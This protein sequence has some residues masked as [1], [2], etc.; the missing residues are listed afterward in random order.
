[1]LEGTLEEIARTEKLDY[2]LVKGLNGKLTYQLTQLDGTPL[3]KAQQEKLST[4]MPKI[5]NG[6]S[7]KLTRDLGSNIHLVMITGQAPQA[8]QQHVHVPSPLSTTPTP[9][10]SPSTDKRKEE[11]EK[12]RAAASSTTSFALQYQGA[13]RKRITPKSPFEG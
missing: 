11:E 7:E 9:G 4:E 12:N 5:F 10:Q 1:M 2:K 13:I 8:K 3:T 6:L